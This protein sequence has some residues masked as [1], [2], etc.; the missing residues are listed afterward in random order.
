[1]TMR[2]PRELAVGAEKGQRG[3]FRVV[4]AYDD[5]TAGKRAMDACNFLGF[6]LGGGVELQSRM[7]KFDILRNPR[8]HEMAVGDAIDADVII[9]A[10]APDAG[11]PEQVA[12][13]VEDWAPRKRGQTAA[14]VALLDFTRKDSRESAQAYA[15]L[16]GAATSASIDFLP[17]KIRLPGSALPPLGRE[18]RKKATPLKPDAQASRPP[19]E[20]WGLND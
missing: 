6:Q 3:A 16:K 13:W 10:N 1:M 15:L 12:R 18:P 5:F 19:P 4:I 9:V 17:H 8:L 2:L 20:A 14:L 7:W 11:L